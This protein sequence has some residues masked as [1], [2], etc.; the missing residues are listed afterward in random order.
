MRHWKRRCRP[1][2]STRGGCTLRRM[3][4]RAHPLLMNVD[5]LSQWNSEPMSSQ[6][7]LPHFVTADH[8]SDPPAAPPIVDA[9]D[10]DASTSETVIGIT[11]DRPYV[12]ATFSANLT[13]AGI[14]FDSR[15]NNHG[16]EN[17]SRVSR[18]QLTNYHRSPP[19]LQRRFIGVAGCYTDRVDRPNS[20]WFS[21]PS[22]L[23]GSR[24]AVLVD[25]VLRY[26]CGLIHP[27]APSQSGPAPVPA[28]CGEIHP[29]SE[30]LLFRSPPRSH[31]RLLK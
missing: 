2:T 25:V 24:G 27:K 6:Y 13:D 12:G 11:S 22:V 8:I 23:D 31:F 9:T 5:V 3:Q 28:A 26:C 16:S 15:P 10:S 19:H 29:H 18:G 1:T 4:Q 30:A 14:L 7:A 20:P 21:P 17:G